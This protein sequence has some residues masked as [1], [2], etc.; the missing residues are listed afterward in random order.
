[1]SRT[2]THQPHVCY[3]HCTNQFYTPTR[4]VHAMGPCP[5]CDAY[6]AKRGDPAYRPHAPQWHPV[7]NAIEVL[8]RPAHAAS[9]NVQRQHQR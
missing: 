5:Y 6:G 4:I 9:A 3:C 8:K 7:R 2:Q 1:M